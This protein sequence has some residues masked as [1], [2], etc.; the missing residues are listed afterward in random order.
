MC[1]WKVGRAV[2]LGGCSPTRRGRR[3]IYDAGM[4]QDLPIPVIANNF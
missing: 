1:L 3:D 2:A 4:Q